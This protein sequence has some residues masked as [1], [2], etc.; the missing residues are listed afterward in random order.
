M[1]FTLIICIVFALLSMHFGVSNNHF[2]RKSYFSF[3]LFQIA[4][5]KLSGSLLYSFLPDSAGNLYIEADGNLV[6]FNFDFL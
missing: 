4:T 2:D 5:F 1:V 3:K 6:Q